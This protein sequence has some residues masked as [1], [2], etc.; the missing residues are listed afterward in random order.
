MFTCFGGTNLQYAERY[1]FTDEDMELFFDGLLHMFDNDQAVARPIGSLNVRK[2]FV[3][4]WK[5]KRKYSD[6]ALR[7]SI[8][9]SLKEGVYM[10]ISFNDYQINV[11]EKEDILFQEMNY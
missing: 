10:P 7:E 11:E 3:W 5:G 6:A 1:E 4:K 2:L 8:R 9:I